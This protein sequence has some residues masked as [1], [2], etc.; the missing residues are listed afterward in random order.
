[1][2]SIRETFVFLNKLINMAEYLIEP[3][4]RCPAWVVAITTP[5]TAA[6]NKLNEEMQSMNTKMNS[7]QTNNDDRFETVSTE[8]MSGVANATKLATDAIELAKSYDERLHKI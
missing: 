8:I 3:P 6:L 1:M 4:A 5:I 7:M 2:Q